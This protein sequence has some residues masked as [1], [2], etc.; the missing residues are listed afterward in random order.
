MT[1]NAIVLLA[2]GQSRRMG[3]INKLLMPFNNEPLIRYSAKL[4][5]SLPNSLVYVVLGHQS[6]QIRAALK[7]LDVCFVFNESYKEG[8]R[9]SV[10]L[11]TYIYLILCL[12]LY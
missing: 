10:F 9:S 5:M 12:L 11:E 2:A 8:Q 6:E 3:D 1:K 4:Y 7:N